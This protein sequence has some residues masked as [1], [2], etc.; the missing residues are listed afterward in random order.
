MVCSLLPLLQVLDIYQVKQSCS[1]TSLMHGRSGNVASLLPLGVPENLTV[2]FT[3]RFGVLFF[4]WFYSFGSQ[5]W[6][7]EPCAVYFD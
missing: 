7:I 6:K 4:S 1:Q 5:Q 2:F 3:C